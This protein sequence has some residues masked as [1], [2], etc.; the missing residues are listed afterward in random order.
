MSVAGEDEMSFELVAKGVGLEYGHGPDAT[1]ALDDIDLTIREGE[2][3][4][5]VGASGC[6]KSSLLNL[7]AGFMPPSRGALLMD[8]TPIRGPGSDRGVVFQEHALFPWMTVRQNI[9]YGLRVNGVARHEAR[10]RV[11]ELVQLIGLT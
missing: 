8:G 1:M 5:I 6:G 11:D 3:V 2:L 9:A 7:V 10:Q 4:T